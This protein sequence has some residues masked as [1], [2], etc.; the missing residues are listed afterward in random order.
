MTLFVHTIMLPS[1]DTVSSLHVL[2]GIRLNAGLTF[3]E[4]EKGDSSKP[5]R[6]S[7]ASTARGRRVK[8]VSSL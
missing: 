5:R 6:A 4:L 1:V 3:V 7:T 2:L 8:R